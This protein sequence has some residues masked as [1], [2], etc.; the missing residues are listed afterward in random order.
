MDDKG[1]LLLAVFGLP[2][3]SHVD[4]AFRAV[5]AALQLVR[6]INRDL[7]GNGD[8]SSSSPPLSSSV[9]L[10]SPPLLSVSLSLFACL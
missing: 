4:D 8:A 10:V 1:S 5:Q 9:F 6:E 2:P 3:L 7:P